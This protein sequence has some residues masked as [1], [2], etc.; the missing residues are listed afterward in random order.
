MKSIEKSAVTQRQ[1]R[2]SESFILVVALLLVGANLRAPITSIGPLLGSIKEST[3]IS[4]TLAGMI[5]TVPLLAF[6]V[7]S[8]FASKLSR[9]FGMER[10]IFCALLFI[11]LGAIGRTLF[12]AG[13][14]FAGTIL[15][16]LGIAV[17]NVLLPS[18]VK[19]EFPNKVGV[20]TGAYTL[21]MNICGALASGISIPLAVQLGI[22]WK[23]A[24]ACWVILTVLALATWL[25]RMRSARLSAATS[26]SYQSHVNM[27]K[28]PL[29]W[30][31]TFFMGLQSFIF[32]NIVSWLPEILMDRGMV[33]DTAGWMLS[34]TQF[35]MMPFTFLVPILASRM[36]SQTP[37][38][39]VTFSL[40]TVGI[41]GL[42]FG[43][44]TLVPLWVSLIG[45]AGSFSFGL[46]MMFFN[47]RTKTAGEAAELS[48]M[49]QSIGYLMAAVGPMMFGY[50]H[51]LTASWTI[52]LFLLFGASI[53]IFICG[54]G[55]AKNRFISESNS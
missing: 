22:G 6:A 39:Y 2:I 37:L 17:C 35:S 20:M 51:D 4:N 16:G 18:L 52:P 31:I 15:V 7:L 32:Y 41:L 19:Q 30:Q 29:A 28:S 50:L 8:P 10:V 38:V 13:S 12:G 45:I 46:V 53:L 40:Y 25:P 48:G 49:A 5:T 36:K 23:G 3:G 34:L 44:T 24:L 26:A 43:S 42:I 54:L 21:S 1:W 55:A 47:L 33:A 9:R 11:A 14:L 27:W